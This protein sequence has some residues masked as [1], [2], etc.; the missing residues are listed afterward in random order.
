MSGWNAFKETQLRPDTT[1]MPFSEP[2]FDPQAGFDG[3]RKERG[4]KIWHCS[5]GCHKNFPFSIKAKNLSYQR[6]FLVEF[7]EI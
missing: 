5:S 3:Q 2:T 4:K 6:S 7:Q 1:P